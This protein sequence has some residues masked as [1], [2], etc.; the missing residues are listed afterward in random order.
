GPALFVTPASALLAALKGDPAARVREAAAE[1]LGKMTNVPGLAKEAVPA[2]AA[3]LK[4]PAPE[5]RRGAAEALRRW[6]KAA[7]PA[8]DDLQEALRQPD[9]STATRVLAA[10]AIGAV[11]HPE[12]VA[13]LPA[14]K[15]V[16][17][18]A[19]APVDVRVAAAE[20]IGALGPDVA[21]AAPLLG[22]LLADP[23]TP[24]PL[25]Q[26]LA[27]TLGKFGPG[28]KPA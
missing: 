12:A 7:Q 28:A 3:A 14:L 21:A 25:R 4:D 17:A 20:A 24:T 13:G 19:K 18:D 27:T 22:Q 9:N 5:P 1:S 8:L 23:E 10:R 16:L 15:D 6:G 26:E 11:G 2:L